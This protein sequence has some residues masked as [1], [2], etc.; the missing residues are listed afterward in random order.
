MRGTFGTNFDDDKGNIAID[1]GWSRTDPLLQ[2]ERPDA[3]VG[4]TAADGNPLYNGPNGGISSVAGVNNSRF[5]E[6]NNNGVLFVRPPGTGPGSYQAAF[7]GGFFVTQSGVPYAAG[8]IPTQFNATGSGLIPYNPGAFPTGTPA[9]AV[10]PV[11]ANGGDGFPYQ[12]LGSLYSGVERRTVN[13]LGHLD[14]AGNIK[15]STELT[16]AHT[17]GDD[18][19]A[20]S[21][22]NTVL[23]DTPSGAGAFVD[24]FDDL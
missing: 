6:F 9:G 23:N 4:Y 5:W 2:S 10:D 7:G 15:L 3:A 13:V 1:L 17:R 14:L 19:F 18:P 12:N 22:S 16:Y 21:V 8:G 24:V 11:F 20:N